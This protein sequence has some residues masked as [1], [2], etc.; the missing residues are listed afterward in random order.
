MYLMYNHK[1][2]FVT[3]C[4]ELEYIHVNIMKCPYLHIAIIKCVSKFVNVPIEKFK[5]SQIPCCPCLRNWQSEYNFIK[6]TQ[7]SGSSKNITLDKHTHILGW[8]SIMNKWYGSIKTDLEI[9][10]ITHNITS[11]MSHDVWVSAHQ[12]F[13]FYRFQYFYY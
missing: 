11:E 2:M 4:L 5:R 10:Y 3:V 8:H 7:Y 12:N 1:S 9:P 13:W 6:W